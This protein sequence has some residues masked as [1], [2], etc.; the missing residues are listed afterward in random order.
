MLVLSRRKG[1]SIRVGDDIVITIFELGRDQV[2]IGISAP[3][4]VNV[5]REEVYDE[6][7][8]ANIAAANDSHGEIVIAAGTQSQQALDQL[9]ARRDVAVAGESTNTISST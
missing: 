6:I 7:L 5:H 4:T 3:R 8:L 9:P 1:E 2:R